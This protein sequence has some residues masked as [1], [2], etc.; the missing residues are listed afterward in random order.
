[1]GPR[2]APLS[3]GGRRGSFGESIIA[4]L[5]LRT[6]PS[7]APRVAAWATA[8]SPTSSLP[9]AV[10][11]RSLLGTGLRVSF[12]HPILNGSLCILF[13]DGSLAWHS[14]SAREDRGRFGDLLDEDQ[15]PTII[16]F[17]ELESLGR[18]HPASERLERPTG[19]LELF[20]GIRPFVAHEPTPDGHQREAVLEKDG[21]L[22]NRP[23]DRPIERLP[24]LRVPPDVFDPSAL[25]GDVGQ[26]EFLCEEVA[27]LGLLP[28]GIDED[29]VSLRMQD[30]E[31]ETGQS[32]STPDISHALT[33]VKLYEMIEHGRVD[34]VL[35]PENISIITAGQIRLL[36]LLEEEIDELLERL[37]LRR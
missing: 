30:G 31:D 32:A 36:V 7:R 19:A 26:T 20:G 9:L 33:R 6:P 13:A 18:V 22:G 29:E 15:G 35:P 10:S 1:M 17:G 28:V 5:P 3:A 14:V 34:D 16:P 4:T 27:G 25:H 12:V 8:P 11:R 23:A 37:L 2:S 21:E 24:I